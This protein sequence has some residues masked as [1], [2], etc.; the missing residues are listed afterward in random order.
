[1]NYRIRK[2][3]LILLFLFLNTACST[4]YTLVNTPNIYLN[5][6]GYPNRNITESMQTVTP[7][8]LFITDRKLNTI[9]DE[10]ASYGTD[11]VSIDG[12]WQS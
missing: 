4:T 12:L 5:E 6:Q 8:I 7:E 2:I 1:M 3:Q 9:V 10:K 11:K